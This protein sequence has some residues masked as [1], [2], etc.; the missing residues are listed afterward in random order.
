[1]VANNSK[2]D[3]FLKYVKNKHP[4]FYMG[5]AENMKQNEK[6]FVELGTLLLS[7][8]SLINKNNYLE[9]L[10]EGYCRFVIDVNKSQLK[11]EKRGAYLNKSYAE[12]L[13][14]GYSNSAFM[15]FY[16][17]GVYVT[18]F[19]WEHH[20]HIYTFFKNYFLPIIDE[21]GSV[22]DLGSGS[23][24]WSFLLINKKKNWHSTAVDI[25]ETSINQSNLMSNLIGLGDK[26]SFIK[27]NAVDFQGKIKFD[28]VISCFLLEHLE[29][30]VDLF[31]N[32]SKNLKTR[33]YAFVTCAL[34]AAEYD[35]IYEFKNESELINIAEKSGLRLIASYS[36][37]P[38]NHPKETFYLP[39]SM[40]LVLQK[41]KNSIW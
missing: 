10:I 11:Y 32:I 9:L 39:R 26:I 2:L 21:S 7:W 19:A 38:K 41:R 6:E 5:I 27:D 17:W 1:M 4:Q 25:S 31:H 23:G 22:L 18:T 13:E 28:S 15:K 16:H 29:K 36:A 24:I 14:K 35:H 8:A 37:S 20:L 40:A 30:P 12:V 34:T 33:G 3:E